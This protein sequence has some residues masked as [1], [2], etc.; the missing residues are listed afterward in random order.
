MCD[1]GVFV[2][3]DPRENPRPQRLERL[4]VAEKTGHADEHVLVKQA[5]LVRCGEYVLDVVGLLFDAVQGHPSLDPAIDRG[6]LVGGQII[7]E[8]RPDE[9][10]QL[11]DLRLNLRRRRP[12]ARQVGVMRNMQEL[13]GDLIRGQREVS[14]AAVDR[15]A[16]HPLE[17]RRTRILGERDAARFL[18][19]LEAE[20]PVCP[21]PREHH[22]DRARSLVLGQRTKEVVDRADAD[23]AGRSAGSGIVCSTPRRI[24]RSALGGIT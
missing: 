11:V 16:G 1:P 7:A 21:R 14:P 23:R 4:G 15:A 2:L 3:Q 17:L 8:R 12:D 18:D 19:R 20:R 13:L 24:A 9:N 22:P 6:R 10:D 5:Q